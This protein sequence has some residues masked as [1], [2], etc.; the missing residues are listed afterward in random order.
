[1]GGISLADTGTY[2]LLRELALSPGWFK[3]RELAARAY[4]DR[5]QAD[6]ISR[7]LA[8]D[9]YLQGSPDGRF[10]LKDGFDLLRRAVPEER[11][12]DAIRVGRACVAGDRDGLKR[13]LVGTNATLCL[14]TAAEERLKDLEVAAVTVYHRRPPHLLQ[15]LAEVR[16]GTIPVDVYHPDLSVHDDTEA[17]GRRTN[18]FRTVVD[19]LCAGNVKVAHRLA[20]ATFPTVACQD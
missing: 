19:L 7:R 8:M 1:M 10:R 20:T 9:G 15:A 18:P 2:R 6:H 3:V 16:E 11:E 13:A 5:Y 4:T 12:M 14:T 17:D